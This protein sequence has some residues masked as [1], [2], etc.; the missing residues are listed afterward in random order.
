MY[1][2]V[3]AFIVFT[4]HEIKQRKFFVVFVWDTRQY[5]FKHA[6]CLFE[7]TNIFF[8]QAFVYNGLLPQWLLAKLAAEAIEGIREIRKAELE[9]GNE[10][11]KSQFPMSFLMKTVQIKKIFFKSRKL[12]LIMFRDIY[13]LQYSTKFNND[14]FYLQIYTNITA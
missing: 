14:C 8:L 7:T 2:S 4:L 5:S 13:R 11:K 1:L 6:F 3:I 9:G 10:K 12:S